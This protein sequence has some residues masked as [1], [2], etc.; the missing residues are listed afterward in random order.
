MSLC[1]LIWKHANIRSRIILPSLNLPKNCH[2]R[3]SFVLK[4]L[5]LIQWAPLLGCLRLAY[6]HNTLYTLLSS[7]EKVCLAA[8]CLKKLAHPLIFGVII[9]MSSTCDTA[10]WFVTH[11]LFFVKIPFTESLLGLVR[12]LCLYLRTL[13][14]GK[15][16]GLTNSAYLTSRGRFCLFAGG[17]VIHVTGTAKPVICTPYLFGHSVSL[18]FSI[19]TSRFVNP[20]G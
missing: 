2:L 8:E 18:P 6:F 10:L 5:A 3:L 1:R 4:Y 14:P 12:H 17:I 7:R 16:T 13:N 20:T 11:S 9:R 19:L 15:S